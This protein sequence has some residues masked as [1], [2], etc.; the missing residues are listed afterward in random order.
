MIAIGWAFALHLCTLRYPGRLLRSGELI[1]AEALRF[2]A[3]QVDITPQHRREIL[4]GLMPVA[5]ATMS[6]A[7]IATTVM[8][9]VR[10]R[11]LI[12]PG[13]FIV[14]QLVSAG[15]APAE[16]Q[17]AHQLTRDLLPA[18]VARQFDLVE[19]DALSQPLASAAAFASR[20][21]RSSIA[22]LK[23]ARRISGPFGR[24]TSGEAAS[25]GGIAYSRPIGRPCLALVTDQEETA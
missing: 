11:R 18:Q 4:V 7:T 19:T 21:R 8:D 3:D 5:L 24:G 10:R 25:P 23:T 17:V 12:V 14:H 22:R 15:M 2:V 16:R 1:L 9:E 6:V 13:P 20:P